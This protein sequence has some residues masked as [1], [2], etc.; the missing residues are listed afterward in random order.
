MTNATQKVL[1]ILT[2][3]TLGVFAIVGLFIVFN[4]FYRLF[5]YFRYRSRHKIQNEGN[6]E[7]SRPAQTI[8]ESVV[9][10]TTEAP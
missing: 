7:S 1:I 6:V 9:V 10:S 8:S 2:F 3:M 4:V 5:L